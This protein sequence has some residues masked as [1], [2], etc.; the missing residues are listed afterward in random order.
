MIRNEARGL[1][2]GQ[3]GEVQNM[4]RTE[5]TTVEMRVGCMVSA[6]LFPAARKPAYLLQLE[7]LSGKSA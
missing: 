3:E 6:E 1:R 5:F 4:S 7:A 2:F